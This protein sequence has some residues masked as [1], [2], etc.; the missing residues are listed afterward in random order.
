MPTELTGSV[1]T[2]F[3][4]LWIKLMVSIIVCFSLGFASGMTERAG[5]VTLPAFEHDRLRL[6]NVDIS[7]TFL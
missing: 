2:E 4:E 1:S 6:R 5:D 7:M 3:S